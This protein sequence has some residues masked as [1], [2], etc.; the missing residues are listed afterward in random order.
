MTWPK[1][2]LV[3]AVVVAVPIVVVLIWQSGSEQTSTVAQQQIAR[4]LSSSDPVDSSAGPKDIIFH[5]DVMAYLSTVEIPTNATTG[6]SGAAASDKI[7][8]TFW[9][10]VAHSTVTLGNKQPQESAPSEQRVGC[11]ECK[12]GAPAPQFVSFAVQQNSD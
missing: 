9:F 7:I 3:L 10:Y 2:L 6:V 11:M 4:T 8:G 5:K 12:G 1:L